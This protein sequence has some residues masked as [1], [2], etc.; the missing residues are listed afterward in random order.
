M[1]AA[2]R[3]PHAASKSQLPGQAFITGVL[4]KIGTKIATWRKDQ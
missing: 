2:I 3:D 1:R 4:Y